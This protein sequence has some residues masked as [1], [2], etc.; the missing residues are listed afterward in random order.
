MEPSA[1][2]LIEAVRVDVAEP[3]E[4]AWESAPSVSLTRYWSGANADVGRHADVRVV[5]TPA[6]LHVRFDCRQSEP[7]VVSPNPVLTEKT[8]GLWE[9][10][11]CEIFI[12]P[13]P[14]EPERYFEFEAA[15]TGE[16]LDLA[17]RQMP[18][19]RETDWEYSSGVKVATLVADQT[20]TIVMR[21]PW[22]AFGRE[23]RLMDE[24]RVNFFR[25]VGR[26]I[27]RGYL[28][29]QPTLTEQPNFHVPAA[30]GW[31]RFVA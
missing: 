24:W 31:L 5:W 4:T 23:P 20:F 6:A 14:D 9:R 12:A 8:V 29:W 3:D 11:V 19:L 21:I 2:Q 16:W 17:I 15:P 27:S 22:A 26:G 10:D 7:L 1:E 13:N 28:T 18:D 30:F 25:C